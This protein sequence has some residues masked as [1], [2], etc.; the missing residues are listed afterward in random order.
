LR[1]AE[2]MCQAGN[3]VPANRAHHDYAQ[4]TNE[5]RVTVR[6]LRINDEDRVLERIQLSEIGLYIV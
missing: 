6:I 2:K 1:L 3:T 4:G 5:A